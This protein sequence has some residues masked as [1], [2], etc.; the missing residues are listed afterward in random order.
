MNIDVAQKALMGVNCLGAIQDLIEIE[1]EKGFCYKIGEDHVI[2]TGWNQKRKEGWKPFLKAQ[3]EYCGKNNGDHEDPNIK[4][5][6]KKPFNMGTYHYNYLTLP[7][8]ILTSIK[9]AS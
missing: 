7:I 8:S 5:R 2:K 4:I 6:I 1:F 9:K 3:G